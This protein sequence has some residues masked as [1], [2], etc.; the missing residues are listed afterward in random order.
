MSHRFYIEDDSHAEQY[1]VHE[2][3]EAAVRELERL[4][5]IPWDKEPNVA[6]CQSWK[7]CG[8]RYEIIE[9]DTSTTPWKMLSRVPA[10]KVSAQGV[11][12]DDKLR[13]D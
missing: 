1:S 8:R 6:P 10:L 4:A 13:R 11:L 2:T 12:W 5:R 7:T 3:F 9:Y